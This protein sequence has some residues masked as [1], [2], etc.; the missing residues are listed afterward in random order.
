LDD[1]KCKVTTKETDFLKIKSSWMTI[2]AK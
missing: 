2:N 1:E